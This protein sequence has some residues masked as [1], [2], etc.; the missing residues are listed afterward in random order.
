MLSIF[1]SPKPA[2]SGSDVVEPGTKRTRADRSPPG[3]PQLEEEITLKDI[4]TAI[5]KIYGIIEQ[6]PTTVRRECQKF[7]SEHKD[8]L[9]A[10]FTPAITQNVVE[11]VEPLITAQISSN[12]AIV[13]ETMRARD[14]LIFN[15]LVALESHEDALEKIIKSPNALLFGVEESIGEA[16]LSQVKSLFGSIRIDE[17]RRLGKFDNKA[18]RPRPV[19]I[20]F[21]SIADKHAAFKKSKLLRQNF[22]VSMDDDLTAKQREG[23]A[24][25]MPQAL[26]LRNEGWTT[27]WRG[28]NLFKVKGQGPPIKVI[29]GQ[30]P[31][32]SSA[33]PMAMA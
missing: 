8:D 11:A 22:K 33:A 15:K 26:A 17:T 5:N 18:K 1:G 32:T 4:M 16:Q 7:L 20:K 9:V 23:R 24:T 3:P 21:G 12:Q 19:L 30:R 13:E 14:E 29:P 25:L 10:A 31:T 27:F 28:E 6:I 2:T